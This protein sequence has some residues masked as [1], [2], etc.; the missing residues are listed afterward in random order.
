MKVL[1]PDVLVPDLLERLGERRRVVIGSN[2][3]GRRT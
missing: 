2:C 1:R 3:N